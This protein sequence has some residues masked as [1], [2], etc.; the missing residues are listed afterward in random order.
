[1]VQAALKAFDDVGYP[2]ALSGNHGAI[3]PGEL[4]GDP[5]HPNFDAWCAFGCWIRDEHAGTERFPL[6]CLQST[7]AALLRLLENV[8][9]YGL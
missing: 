5:A 1:L 3:E 6:T 4:M 2:A 8:T 9:L 7:Y